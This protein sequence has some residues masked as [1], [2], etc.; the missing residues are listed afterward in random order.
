LGGQRIILFIPKEYH[1][2]ADISIGIRLSMAVYNP[3][4]MLAADINNVL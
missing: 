3:E 4:Q 2:A 1:V